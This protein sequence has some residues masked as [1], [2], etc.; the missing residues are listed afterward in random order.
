MP[1]QSVKTTVN[2]NA[3][4]S[5]WIIEE[6]NKRPS[7]TQTDI[8]NRML[9]DAIALP[10]KLDALEKERKYIYLKTLF[11]LRE[12][13]RTRGEGFVEEIDEQ[14]EESLPLMEALVSRG[15]DFSE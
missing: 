5:R 13:A 7:S 8:I 9:E 12:L 11:I 10:K 1:N 4:V 15:V 3:N 6:Q 2:L 14:F